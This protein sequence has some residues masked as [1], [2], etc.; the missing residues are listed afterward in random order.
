MTAEQLAYELAL[1]YM[2]QEKYS[3]ASYFDNFKDTYYTILDDIKADKDILH[4]A[5]INKPT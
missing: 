2:Q 3:L 1:R 4:N 5:L